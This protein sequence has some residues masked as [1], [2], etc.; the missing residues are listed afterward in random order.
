M[1]TFCVVRTRMVCIH[2][3]FY[4]NFKLKQLRMNFPRSSFAGS[5]GHPM[6]SKGEKRFAS[7]EGELRERAKEIARK[8][9]LVDT[10]V[11]PVRRTADGAACKFGFGNT[12]QINRL[13]N[14][15]FFESGRKSSN[16]PLEV[17]RSIVDTNIKSPGTEKGSYD[18]HTHRA[19]SQSVRRKRS[20]RLGRRWYNGGYFFVMYPAMERQESLGKI[21]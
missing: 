8:F 15:E 18:H 21:V 6:D 3:E 10:V 20:G 17:L 12:T 13:R 5:A 2:L 16:I 11:N 1:K 19:Q 14:V 4:A 9:I 7:C